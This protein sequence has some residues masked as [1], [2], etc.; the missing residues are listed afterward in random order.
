MKKVL[1]AFA[2]I[3]LI[4][5]VF[6]LPNMVSSIQ[7]RIHQKEQKKIVTEVKKTHK[8][9]FETK[10]GYQSL[11]KEGKRVYSL[12]YYGIFNRKKEIEIEQVTTKRMEDIL[13]QM[14]SDC[15]ELFWFDFTGNI[16]WKTSG[17]KKNVVFLPH[18]IFTE[19]QTKQ[20]DKKIQKSL[21]QYLSYAGKKETEYEKAYT[22]YEHLTK[23]ISYREGSSHNQ[24][25]V[26]GM[27]NEETV[28]TGYAKSLQYIYQKMGI[29]CRMVYGKA[30][31]QNHAWNLVQI[32]GI[33]C[34]VDPTWGSNNQKMSKGFFGM[35]EAELLRGHTLDQGLKVPK[36][37]SRKNNYYV[38]QNHY[39]EQ[40][41]LGKIYAQLCEQ[42]SRG[43]ISFQLGSQKEYEKAHQQLITDRKIFDLLKRVPGF[44]GRQMKVTYYTDRQLY[45][46]TF[47]FK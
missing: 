17:K 41:D 24:N 2:S 33:D 36:C 4:V 47:N 6:M 18:Y 3:L 10:Y 29:R 8:D 37:S 1:K 25:L 19:K 16:K 43:Q 26:S 39:Y 35:T 44:G 9:L 30:N 42:K 34:Y 31:G 40:F 7:S 23:G 21:A 14:E 28:C 5:L 45:I 46:M 11:S 12:M 13:K 15:P 27:V 20:Y 32:E 38:R 22:V